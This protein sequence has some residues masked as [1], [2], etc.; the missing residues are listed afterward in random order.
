[1]ILM[2]D[3][4]DFGPI[5]EIYLNIPNTSRTNTSRTYIGALWWGGAGDLALEQSSQLVN[6]TSGQPALS[7]GGTSPTV[8]PCV[9]S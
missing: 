7:R 2:G 6:R 5:T 1:M 4:L 3:D 8:P 9:W